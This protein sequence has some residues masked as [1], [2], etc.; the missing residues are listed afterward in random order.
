M[1]I[2]YF[3]DVCDMGFFNRETCL[4]HERKHFKDMNKEDR[5]RLICKNINKDPCVYCTHS[6]YVYGC[7]FDCVYYKKKLCGRFNNFELLEAKDESI[8]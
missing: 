1:T 3:C 4:E 7:E 6:Y 2:K 5:I 8:Q